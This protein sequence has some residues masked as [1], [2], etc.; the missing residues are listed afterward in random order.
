MQALLRIP[1]V[2]DH[3]ESCVENFPLDSMLYTRAQTL[4]MASL[5]AI[6]GTTRWLARNSARK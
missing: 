5:T 3:A 1:Q 2:I 4:Y 6:E